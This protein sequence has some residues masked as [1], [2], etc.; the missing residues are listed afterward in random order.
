MP[1][2]PT[3]A[4][5][6]RTCPRRRSLRLRRLHQRQEVAH[7]RRAPRRI[8]RVAEHRHEA[9]RHELEPGRRRQLA[10]AAADVGMAA[11]ASLRLVHRVPVALERR[12]RRL[13]RQAVVVDL[14]D[15]DAP[16]R[17]HDARDLAHDRRRIGD[18]LEQPADERRRRPTPSAAA[19]PS[20][21]RASAR[22]RRRR[23]RSAST[24]R[25]CASCPSEMSQPTTRSCGQR[26]RRRRVSAPTP[27]PTSSSVPTPSSATPSKTQGARNSA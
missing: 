7:D 22:P 25:A 6:R 27:M 20:P 13:Q 8:A 12:L 17:P 26:A 24:R 10:E 19:A 5:A 2:T 9:M 15:E 23:R 4:R 18:V 21:T 16:A 1:P 14:G 11:G 3:A